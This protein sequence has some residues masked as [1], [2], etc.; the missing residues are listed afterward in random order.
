MSL[1]AELTNL[2]LA[3]VLATYRTSSPRE[4]REAEFPF[5]LLLCSSAREAV[6]CG[7]PEKELRWVKSAALALRA[8]IMTARRFRLTET[9]RF[10]RETPGG[11]F[12]KAMDGLQAK[13]AISEFRVPIVEEAQACEAGHG[14]FAAR[15][16]KGIG[17]V[18]P[19]LMWVAVVGAGQDGEL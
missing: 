9:E 11:E 19:L 10:L 16:G 7:L 12:F 13:G 4:I 14:E 6:R 5:L 2:A 8:I 17:F 18:Y 1:E 3:D 15:L